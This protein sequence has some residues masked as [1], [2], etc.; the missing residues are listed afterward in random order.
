[1][2]RYHVWHKSL[3]STLLCRLIAYKCKHVPACL[4]C[5]CITLLL[6][7]RL[8]NFILDGITFLNVN[9]TTLS[10]SYVFRNGIANRLIGT[11]IYI[12]G[13]AHFFS[14]I[15]TICGRGSI[16][17]QSIFTD[18]FRDCSTLRLSDYLRFRNINFVTYLFKYLSTLLLFATIWLRKIIKHAYV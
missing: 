9:G 16:P 12:F 17:W 2:S 15:V 10:F 3:W 14:S 8:T 5:N 7:H 18:F 6:I 4:S 13:I 1:M 11:Y